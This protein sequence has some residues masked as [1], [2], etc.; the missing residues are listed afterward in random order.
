MKKNIEQE[1]AFDV[2]NDNYKN[3]Y[4]DNFQIDDELDEDIKKFF[5]NQNENNNIINNININNNNNLLINNEN[6]NNDFY[7]NIYEDNLKI[8]INEVYNKL[9]IKKEFINVVINEFNEVKNKLNELQKNCNYNNNFCKKLIINKNILIP[10]PNNEILITR[11]FPFLS[12][13]YCLNQI[14]KIKYLIFIEKNKDLDFDK[15]FEWLYTFLLLIEQ[16][17]FDF[18]NSILFELNKLI[19]YNFDLL[20]KYLNLKISFIIISEIYKQRIFQ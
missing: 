6:D 19:Y 5:N 1:I 2:N 12:N 9:N 11:I 20:N 7:V 15:I 10:F 3:F 18:E 13:K 8:S 17:L 16:P 4:P 14:K